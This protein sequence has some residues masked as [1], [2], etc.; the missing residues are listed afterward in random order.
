[1]PLDKRLMRLLKNLG[2][3]RM[4]ELKEEGRGNWLIHSLGIEG[5]SLTKIP[6]HLSNNRKEFTISLYKI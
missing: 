2:K 1:M 3:M 5:D 4:I 6:E